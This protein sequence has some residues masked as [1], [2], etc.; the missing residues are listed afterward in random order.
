MLFPA[1][2]SIGIPMESILLVPAPIRPYAS[3]MYRAI[4]EEKPRGRSKRRIQCSMLDGALRVN[5]QCQ[6]TT[7]RGNAR[8]WSL[9]MIVSIQYFTYGTFDGQRCRSERWYLTL[10]RPLI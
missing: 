2:L 5:R 10:Q 7:E 8:S 9:V 6:L 3:G 4:A 1:T